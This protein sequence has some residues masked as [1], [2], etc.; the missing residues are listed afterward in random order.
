MTRTASK[1]VQ[2]AGRILPVGLAIQGP[3][4]VNRGSFWN[5]S[6][7]A[8]YDDGTFKT[9]NATFSLGTTSAAIM[10]SEGVLNT[11]EVASEDT[12]TIDASYTESGFTVSATMNVAIRVQGALSLNRGFDG[13]GQVDS[14]QTE[15]SG[16]NIYSYALTRN[17]GGEIVTRTETIGQMSLKYDY[18]YDSLGRLA[19]VA[20]NGVVIE[21]YQYGAN[22]T[23]TSEFNS[24]RGIS[25]VS[26]SY[27]QEDNLV[28][29]GG[30]TYAYDADGFL[31]SKTV[32]SLVTRY[33]YS[34]LGELLGVTFPNGT[35][36]TI[37]TIRWAEG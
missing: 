13:F 29:A 28:S 11:G 9:V 19:S 27:S 26:L 2:I 37:H 15:I 8:T 23:R 32:G 25:N 16:Q 18:T 24:L 34:T 5:Y 10:S 21:Q 6:A 36:F 7:L 4:T 31:S 20:L 1:T 12:I 35:S 17:A 3:A 14:E 33:T 30:A 22:G